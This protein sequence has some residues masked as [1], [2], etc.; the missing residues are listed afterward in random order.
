MAA[1]RPGASNSTVVRVSAATAASAR[2]APGPN[3]AG[4][5]RSRTG[6][7]RSPLATRAAR[8]AEGP[9]TTVTSAR[10]RPPRRPPR[11]PGSETPGIP[12]S[13]TRATVPSGGQARPPRR[14]GRP[15][16]ARGATAA[17]PRRYRHGSAASG[18]AGVLAVDDVRRRQRLDGPGDRSPR[19]PIGVP[20]HHHG[21]PDRCRRAPGPGRRPARS[22]ASTRS[23]GG[24]HPRSSRWSPTRRP[25]RSKA[26]AWASITIGPPPGQAHPQRLQPWPRPRTT[27][28]RSQMA[29]SMANRIP[30]VWTDRVRGRTIAP[31]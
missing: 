26:P 2:C 13:V 7:W 27:M 28:S 21:R 20:D 25:Q 29:T 23:A 19:L 10:R 31:S 6:R 22:A 4:S 14:P 12:A 11:P 24:R 15:R 8:T 18:V 16:C 5:P 30:T 3:G 9:G 17:A 1:T